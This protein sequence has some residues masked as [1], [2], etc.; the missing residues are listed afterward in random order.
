FLQLTASLPCLL[1]AWGGLQSKLSL[2]SFVFA[3]LGDAGHG[4]GIFPIDGLQGRWTIHRE[5]IYIGSELMIVIVKVLPGDF[6][7]GMGGMTAH[8]RNHT[9]LRAPFDFVVRSVIS[10]GVHEIFPLHFVR[11][12]RVRLRKGRP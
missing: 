5:F 1:Q 12:G 10:D 7:P 4:Y 8:R 3:L 9:R 11:V 6:L 2:L